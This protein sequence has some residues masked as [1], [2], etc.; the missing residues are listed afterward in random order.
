ME[1][2]AAQSDT[3]IDAILA[4]GEIEA[5]QSIE[6]KVGSSS[7]KLTPAGIKV[8]PTPC[9]APNANAYAERV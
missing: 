7:I 2:A 3:V 6:L 1:A 4:T 9:R 5:M 8:I